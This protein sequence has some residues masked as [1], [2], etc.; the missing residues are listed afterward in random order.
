MKETK[1]NILIAK[2]FTMKDLHEIVRLCEAYREA[3]KREAELWDTKYAPALKLL[4]ED[5]S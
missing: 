4:A 5:M 1:E 3:K 2:K